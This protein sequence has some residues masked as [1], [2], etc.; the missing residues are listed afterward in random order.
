M[1]PEEQAALAQMKASREPWSSYLAAGASNILNTAQGFLPTALGGRGDIGVSDIAMGAATG[2][3]NTASGVKKMMTGETP[4]FLPDGSPN[5]AAV[6][7]SFD[8]A[9]YLTGASSAVPGEP[10]SL[11][12]GAQVAPEGKPR[13]TVVD[14]PK[15]R[16]QRDA[17]G[18]YSRAEEALLNWQPQKNATVQQF[19]AFMKD[20]GVK[21][22]EIDTITRAY[23]DPT[24]PADPKSLQFAIRKNL[25]QFNIV[26]TDKWENYTM[27]GGT[28][29][30]MMNIQ[31]A[32]PDATYGMHPYRNPVHNSPDNTLAFALLKDDV[33]TDPKTNTA[34]KVLRVEEFQ[35]DPS[36]EGK[37][38]WA[39]PASPDRIDTK[40]VAVDSP[41]FQKYYSEI[42]F[43]K[44]FDKLTDAEK[45][46][47]VREAEANWQNKGL[48]KVTFYRVP[49]VTKNQWRMTREPTD[50]E[51]LYEETRDTYGQELEESGPA[52]TPTTPVEE[53]FYNEK[54]GRAPMP[55][56]TQGSSGIVPMAMK[57]LLI[58]A[59][60]KGQDEIVFAPGQAL[61]NRYA[62]NDP[63]R[64]KGLRDY[65][66]NIIPK[67][68]K[69]LF[70]RIEQESGIKGLKAEV[71]ERPFI[72]VGNSN[73]DPYSQ[74][75]VQWFTEQDLGEF[76]L[77][78]NRDVDAVGVLFNRAANSIMQNTG[79]PDEVFTELGNS[80]QDMLKVNTDMAA[81][82]EQIIKQ[83]EETPTDQID[84]LADYY[85][86]YERALARREQ[87]R[88]NIKQ[89]QEKLDL[90]PKAR[91]LFNYW[92]T[93]VK[94]QPTPE[95]KKAL[96]VKLAPE[97]REYINKYGLEYFAKG[98]IV[99]LATINARRQRSAF[100]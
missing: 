22:P 37:G 81:Q 18:F 95:E 42:V 66:D 86:R 68:L 87:W 38:K 41:D 20:Y 89:A 83:L 21:Q 19:V 84:S 56:A 98:G 16:P 59:A 12:M 51:F 34:K 25:P 3:A 57:H 63:K 55:Y 27:P 97:L 90:L 93:K 78:A 52:A 65:Q 74:D 36:Q 9:G 73:L 33:Y 29:Y 2:A 8:A 46:T 60:Q 62:T 85:D 94:R 91:E 96:V 76:D 1:T 67:E 35:S 11:R 49:T 30:R 80:Y 58:E 5:P 47:L 10:N 69:P 7:T 92:E 45:Q 24:I 13:T 14:I 77:H 82:N 79:T 31:W 6:A 70:K 32:N 40:T 48:G 39:V 28:N 61:V 43:Q 26:P 4:L 54:F 23:P 15:V 88:T 44:P 72:D 17:Q 64:A 53:M 71:E 100:A 99:D 50:A 75:P